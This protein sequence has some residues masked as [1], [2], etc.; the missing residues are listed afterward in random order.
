MRRWKMSRE[1]GIAAAQAPRTA[2]GRTGPR[3]QLEAGILGRL[4]NVSYFDPREKK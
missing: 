2:Q 3:T 1:D 4:Q